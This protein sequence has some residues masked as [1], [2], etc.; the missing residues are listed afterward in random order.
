MLLVTFQTVADWVEWSADVVV[1]LLGEA[2][3]IGV[4]IDAAVTVNPMHL[5]LP[6]SVGTNSYE[7]E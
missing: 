6:M 4:S 2:G 1:C 7:P 5:N 3:H